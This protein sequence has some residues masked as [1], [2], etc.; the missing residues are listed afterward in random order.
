MGAKAATRKLPKRFH[1]VFF[2]VSIFQCFK[3][4]TFASLFFPTI[5]FSIFVC[6]QRNA[7]RTPAETSRAGVQ[8]LQEKQQQDT[9]SEHSPTPE[10]ISCAQFRTHVGRFCDSGELCLSDREFTW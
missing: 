10:N 1:F 4:F 6:F 3:C 5:T 7:D 8:H 2:N 9:E